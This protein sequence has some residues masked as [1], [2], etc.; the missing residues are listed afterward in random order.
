MNPDTFLDYYEILEISETATTEEIR[1]A[2]KKKA[3]ETH[4]DRF[5]PGASDSAISPTLSQEEAKERFQKIADAYYVLSEETRREQ[6]DRVRASRKKNGE[7]TPTWD[8]GQ[9]DA[10]RVFG[11]VFEELLRPE[12]EN[13]QWF[14]A[15]IGAVTGGTLGFI[16]A[17]IPGLVLGAYAGNKLGAIRD[18]KGVSVYDAYSKL[19]SN[20]KAAILSA[21][22]AKLITSGRI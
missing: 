21:L 8:I 12:V 6:Y 15:P 9:A 11:N 7:S 1:D 14:Y 3:L 22:A 19:S 16:C 2:Y 18:A 20:H 5:A 13:P 4:P 10:N 17:N